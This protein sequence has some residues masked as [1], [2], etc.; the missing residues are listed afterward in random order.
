MIP[1]WPFAINWHHPL[2]RGVRALYLPGMAGDSSLRELVTRER[3]TLNGN[4]SVRHSTRGPVLSCDG[5]DDDATYSSH[6]AGVGGSTYTLAVWA[7]TVGAPDI[8]GNVLWG[9]NTGTATYFQIHTLAQD[10]FFIGSAAV[11][12][13]GVTNW[14]SGSDR[15]V[16]FVSAAG[17]PRGYLNGAS[18]GTPSGTCPTMTTAAKAVQIGGWIG[19]GTWDFSGELLIAVLATEAWGDAEAALWHEQPM[20]MLEEYGRTSYFLPP[21]VGGGAVG[22][23]LW[24]GIF[25]SRVAA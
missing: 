25:R 3:A 24:S 16:V 18:V 13:A 17:S 9:T 15:S 11:L 6:L 5:V 2:A 7:P 1:R 22:G 4:A 12:T 14:Y 10:R 23:V 19:G 21:V 8:N 20:S